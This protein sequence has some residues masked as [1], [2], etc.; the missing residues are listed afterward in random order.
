[1][2]SYARLP[3]RAIF[4]GMR[5][6]VASTVLGISALVAEAQ[7]AAPA[8]APAPAVAKTATSANG[9]APPGWK[10][11]TQALGDLNG[12]GRPDLVFVLLA[13]DVARGARDLPPGPPRRLGVAFARPGGRYELV[14][15][16]DIFLPRRRPP[17]GL[18]QGAMLFDDGSLLVS[19]G[20][21]R[22]IFEYT[23]GHSTFTFRWQDRALRLIGYDNA[24]VE[25]GCLHQLS[26]DFLS[27]RAKMVAADIGSDEERVRWRRLA[28]RPLPTLDQ[29][30][31]GEEYD[32]YN[33]LADFPLT[34]AQSRG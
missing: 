17:N 27:H 20:R 31:E 11:E 2:P 15:R 23:R 5:N 7:G 30:G 28:R 8:S 12:D 25:A 33:L 3:S 34:C 16:N 1:M 10:V 24:G 14:L 26:V 32:P 29:I 21:L 6:K 9:F 18:S 13:A 19:G 4:R 22:T